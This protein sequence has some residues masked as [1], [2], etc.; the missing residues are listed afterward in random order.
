MFSVNLGGCN[1]YKAEVTCFQVNCQYITVS[2]HTD[3]AIIG[4]QIKVVIR[5]CLRNQG[6]LTPFQA[7]LVGLVS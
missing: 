4:T 7:T 5:R 6:L 2:G 1:V 3:D